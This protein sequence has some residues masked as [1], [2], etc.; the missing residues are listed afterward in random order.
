M[1]VIPFFFVYNPALILQGQWLEI[2]LVV[3][4]ALLGVGLISAV[5]QGYLLGVGSLV[6]GAL[7]WLARLLLLAGGLMLAA[8]SGIK[9][10]LAALLLATTGV[11]IPALRN[12][13]M[14]SQPELRSSRA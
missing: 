4:T 10:V 2:L 14:L 13:R 3:V 7:G 5:L 8:P 11:L 12:R 6:G 9:L 1:Y